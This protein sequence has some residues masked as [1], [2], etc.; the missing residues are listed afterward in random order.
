MATYIIG[1]SSGPELITNGN[2]ALDPTSN[3]WTLGTA[4]SWGGGKVTV[5]YIG[6][7]DPTISTSVSTVS[8]KSYSISFDVSGASGD[9]PES[10]FVGNTLP[11]GQGPYS[12]GPNFI[13]FTS[14]YTGTD[15]LTFDNYAWNTGSTWSIDNVSVKEVYCNLP[16]IVYSMG[17]S[18]L[19]TVWNAKVINKTTWN[20]KASGL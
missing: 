10:W 4:A 2:F 20:A 8:G 19:R 13:V 7:N 12:N 15:I 1:G 3:G 9:Y 14:N 18:M 11:Y 16:T 6:S 5:A 17:L